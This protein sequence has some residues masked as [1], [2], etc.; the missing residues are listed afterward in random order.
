[1]ADIVGIRTRVPFE[2]LF[3]F[4]AVQM[5]FRNMMKGAENG[6]LQEA[7]IPFY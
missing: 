2:V 4:V 5:G 1:V 7:E 3:R 6:A